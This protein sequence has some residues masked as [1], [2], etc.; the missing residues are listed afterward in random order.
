MNISMGTFKSFFRWKKFVSIMAF[1]ISSY[2]SMFLFLEL[3]L[4]I[5]CLFYLSF[6][7]LN[8]LFH[9]FILFYFH[10]LSLHTSLFSKQLFSKVNITFFNVPNKFLYMKC[11]FHYKIFL[12]LLFTCVYAHV[13]ILQLNFPMDFAI[14]LLILLADLSFSVTSTGGICSRLQCCHQ[15][16]NPDSLF[17][18]IF[19]FLHIS[20]LYP[21]NHFCLRYYYMQMLLNGIV[22]SALKEFL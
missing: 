4:F 16:L 15:L 1:V 2:H 9:Y 6:I 8:I 20:S 7:S 13:C 5:L 11:G 19:L 18:I 17:K 10:L 22:V 12:S 3:L 21:R 14:L